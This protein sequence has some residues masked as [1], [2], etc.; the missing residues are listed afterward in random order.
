[1]WVGCIDLLVVFWSLVFWWIDEL[2]MFG[3]VIGMGWIILD[4]LLDF[5][6][7]GFVGE[8]IVWFLLFFFVW[9]LLFS[10]FIFFWVLVFILIF[11]SFIDGGEGC[12][13]IGGF[14][15]VCCFLI[16]VL[17]LMLVVVL[18]LGVKFMELLF[19]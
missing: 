6:G 5:V 13:L 1:M 3:D 14:G 19:L 10:F 8:I 16:G 12:M 9:F 17:M 15:V 7:M 18:M 11:E 2:F 4:V